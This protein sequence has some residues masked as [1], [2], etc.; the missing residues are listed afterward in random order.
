[1]NF[2]ELLKQQ[3]GIPPL[4]EKVCRYWG[5][6]PCLG[7][8]C[9]DYVKSL[10]SLQL[11]EGKMINHESCICKDDAALLA[12]LTLGEGITMLQNMLARLM[13][14]MRLSADAQQAPKNLRA[15]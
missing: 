1:M 14:G 7:E 13:L 8:A 12:Q 15:R 2:E 6:T 3:Y 10:I 9:Q 5:F 11:P 4:R